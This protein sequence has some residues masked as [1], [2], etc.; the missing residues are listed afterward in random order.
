MGHSRGECRQEVVICQ[1]EVPDTC[2]P[3]IHQIGDDDAA[4]I[5]ASLMVCDV[6]GA[7]VFSCL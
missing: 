4:I 2:V 6:T 7:V 5:A 3:A 1:A